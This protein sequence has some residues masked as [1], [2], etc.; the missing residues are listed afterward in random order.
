M[1]ERERKYGMSAIP[2]IL[3]TTNG[4][5]GGDVEEGRHKKA[6][7]PPPFMVVLKLLPLLPPPSFTVGRTWF[8]HTHTRTYL[9]LLC[10]YYTLLQRLLFLL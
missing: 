7:F 6:F 8:V 4:A 3:G 9:L 10:M 5:L 2:L 1:R